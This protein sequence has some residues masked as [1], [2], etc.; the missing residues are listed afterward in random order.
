MAST[1][2]MSPQTGSFVTRKHDGKT[3]L[4]RFVRTDPEDKTKQFE[5]DVSDLLSLNCKDPS[6][7]CWDTFETKRT[8][9]DK[10]LADCLTESLNAEKFA[11]TQQIMCGWHCLFQSLTL[12]ETSLHFIMTSFKRDCCWNVPGCTTQFRLECLQFEAHSFSSNVQ[13]SGTKTGSLSLLSDKIRQN[14]LIL[15]ISLT[16]HWN[17]LSTPL[18]MACN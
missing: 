3:S 17:L 14:R 18:Q 13:D 5:V 1:T 6:Q 9:T 12:C 11:K 8:N 2:I 4:T 16:V 7:I 15:L 10:Q